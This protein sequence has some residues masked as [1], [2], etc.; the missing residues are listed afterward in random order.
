MGNILYSNNNH[1]LDEINE[2][3][4]EIEKYQ[5]KYYDLNLDYIQ[6]SIDY[7]KATY[8]LKYVLDENESKKKLEDENKENKIKLL[9]ESIKVL[10][11]EKVHINNELK[12][13]QTEFDIILEE[14]ARLINEI[15]WKKSDLNNDFRNAKGRF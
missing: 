4:I 8:E 1:L 13:L 2:K 12:D 3:N 5:K 10:E 7:D 11:E 14:N 15:N 9:S 6:Q